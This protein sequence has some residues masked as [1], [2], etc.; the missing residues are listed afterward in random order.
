M[1]ARCHSDDADSVVTRGANV[2]GR[3]AHCADAGMFTGSGAGPGESIAIDVRTVF[4][5]VTECVEMKQLQKSAGL[6]LEA[7]DSFQVSGCD[8]ED[9]AA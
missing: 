1:Y 2:G 9:C 3:V 5:F 7:A 6:Q 8:S 4:E